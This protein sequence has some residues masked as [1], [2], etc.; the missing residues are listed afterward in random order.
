MYALI[1]GVST[2]M[3]DVPLTVTIP[4][5]ISAAQFR[6]AAYEMGLLSNIE[7]AVDAADMPTQLKYKHAQYF[8]RNDPMLLSMATLLNYTSQQIDDLFILGNTK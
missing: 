2:L 5:Q 4:Q 6:I 1:N 3:P 7:A 8:D